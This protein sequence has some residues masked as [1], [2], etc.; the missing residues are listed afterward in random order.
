MGSPLLKYHS[1]FICTF[2]MEY[3]FVLDCHLI[4]SFVKLRRI[5]FGKCSKIDHLMYIYV[6]LIIILQL[7]AHLALIPM[8]LSNHELTVVCWFN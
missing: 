3:T 2:V 5:L 1:I 7:L 4:K 6:P 8:S